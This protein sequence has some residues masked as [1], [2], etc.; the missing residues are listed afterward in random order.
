MVDQLCKE[1]QLLLGNIN[2]LTLQCDMYLQEVNVDFTTLDKIISIL[3]AFKF[4]W[5]FS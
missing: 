2:D 1:I 5:V 4:L 3:S